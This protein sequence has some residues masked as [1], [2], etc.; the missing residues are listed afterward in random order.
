MASPPPTLAE[1][2]ER[3]SGLPAARRAR[4]GL[5][6][7]GWQVISQL[8]RGLAVLPPVALWVWHLGGGVDLGRAE[9]PV[10]VALGGGWI[11][12]CEAARRVVRR[13]VR[14]L[15]LEALEGAPGPRTLSS[16]VGPVA[17]P[18]A[19]PRRFSSEVPLSAP[20]SPP[21]ILVRAGRGGGQGAEAPVPTSHEASRSR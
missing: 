11:L 8:L 10:L 3:Y 2:R 7:G 21:S 1:L 13:R 5:A 18:A 19:L 17:V 20:Q 16:S 4:Y 9:G 15:F 6:V 12:L 14:D